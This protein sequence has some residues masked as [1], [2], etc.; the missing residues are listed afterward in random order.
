M[1]PLISETIAQSMRMSN[2]WQSRNSDSLIWRVLNV[3]SEVGRQ[4]E[5]SEKLHTST[6]DSLRWET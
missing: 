2:V 6:V 3:L 1:T 5:A 4:V